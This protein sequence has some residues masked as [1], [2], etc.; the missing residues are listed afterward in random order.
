ML[1]CQACNQKV[2]GS[3]PKTE[4]ARIYFELPLILHSV[5]IGSMLQFFCDTHLINI[6]TGS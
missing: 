2:L 4:F 3:N 5:G 6:F 1:K